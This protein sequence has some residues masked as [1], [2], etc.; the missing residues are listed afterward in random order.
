MKM[1]HRKPSGWDRLTSALTDPVTVEAEGTC[2]FC[3][4][5][6]LLMLGLWNGP[7]G[8]I[9]CQSRPERGAN[10]APDTGSTT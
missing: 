3:D 2:R 9:T 6:I 10:H 4:R 7:D 8:E 5:P 1:L